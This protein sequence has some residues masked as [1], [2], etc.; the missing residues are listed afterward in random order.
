MTSIAEFTMPA[1]D[2]PLGRVFDVAPE[3]RLELDRVVPSDDTFM[4][5]FWVHAN[6]VEAVLAVFETLPELRSIKLMENLADKGLFRAE[7]NP[8]FK[9]IMDAIVESGVTVVSASGSREGWLFELRTDTQDAF[10][11]FRRT[12]TALGLKVNLTRLSRLSRTSA[13]DEEALT[14]E[15]REALLLAYQSGYYEDERES[16]LE[17]LAETLDISRQA[18]AARLRRGYRNLIESVL[19]GSDAV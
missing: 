3:A 8:E 10:D 19:V 18:F 1:G 16:D 15:Q 7:W 9:G 11:Q 12:C 14:P 17:T 5:Y 2:F 4:P 13:A 6:D